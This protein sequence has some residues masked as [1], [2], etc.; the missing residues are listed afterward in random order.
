VRTDCSAN[1]REL[2]TDRLNGA[3]GLGRAG[4]APSAGAGCHAS[5]RTCSASIVNAAAALAPTTSAI[6]RHRLVQDALHGIGGKQLHQER[7]E[8]LPI[9]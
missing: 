1:E 5:S 6:Q 2:P 9:G 8:A 3:A 4:F 7:R